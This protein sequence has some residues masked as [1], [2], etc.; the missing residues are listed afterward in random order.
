MAP[1]C[2]CS[3]GKDG[4][5]G[6]GPAAGAVPGGAAAGAAGGALSCAA[7][8]AAGGGVGF[9]GDDGG[10]V[11]PICTCSCGKDGGVGR[12]PAELELAVPEAVINRKY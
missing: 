11:A 3:G 1:I 10:S 12:G 7:A 2:T 6:C 4:G 8:G 5:V 9:G